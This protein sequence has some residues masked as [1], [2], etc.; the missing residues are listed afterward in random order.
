MSGKIRVLFLCTG[1]SCRSQM[2]EGWARQLKGDLLEPYSAGI[3]PHGLDPRAVAIMAEA[4]VDISSHC[5][6]HVNELKSL[7]FDFV[8]TV[9]DSAQEHCPIFPGPARVIHHSFDDPPRLARESQSETE[10]LGYYRRVRDE[11]RAFIESLPLAL[12]T[13]EAQ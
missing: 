8:I 5:S 10:A 12:S 6:K 7:G 11:I 13:S 9:C 3:E 1:N 2:A 4:G